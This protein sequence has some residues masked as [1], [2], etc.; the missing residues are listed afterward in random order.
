[1][2]ATAVLGL[3]MSPGVRPALHPCQPHFQTA[4]ISATS[5]ELPPPTG[6]HSVGTKIYNWV[7][8]ARHEMASK[9]PRELRQVIVQVWYPSED[10]SGPV[11]PYV[12]MLSSYRRVWQASEVDVARR[13]LTHSRLNTK[14]I[15]SVQ[16]PIVLLSHGWEGTRSEYTS[17][18]EDLGSHGYAVFGVDHPCMGRIALPNGEVTEATENQFHSPTEIVAYYA[19]DLEFVIR[20]IAELNR[21]DPEKIFLGKFDMTRIAAIGHSSGFVAASGACRQDSRIRACVN[22]DAPGFRA[23]DLV[24]LDQPLL[25]IRLEKASSVPARYLK[26]AADVV[27]ELRIEHANHGSVEDWDYLE[28]ASPPQRQAAERVLQ[29]IRQYVEA[30]LARHLDHQNS[31]LLDQNSGQPG[32]QWRVYRPTRS[33]KLSPKH[34]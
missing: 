30:F 17:L 10:Q 15:P 13:T 28:G 23:S 2:T 4:G 18:A 26:T 1:M 3:V 5:I 6:R 22:I 11:A 12:P 34:P 19:A 33:S 21:A 29:I 7:D 25:W 31:E 32:I 16:V 9:N 20:R 14:P 27:Y 24:G 8:D